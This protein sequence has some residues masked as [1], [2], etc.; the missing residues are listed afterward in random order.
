MGFGKEYGEAN[1]RFE[2]KGYIMISLLFNFA[3]GI[4]PIW[5]LIA[6]FVWIL[7]WT[8]ILTPLKLFVVFLH[9]LSH[10]AAAYL[11]GGKLLKFCVVARKG[12]HALTRGGSLFAILNAGYL[13]SFLWGAAIIL[14]T[15]WTRRDQELSLLIGL[16]TAV[17]TLFYLRNTFGFIFGIAFGTGLIVAGQ[18]FPEWANDILLRVIGFTCC[19]YAILDIFDDVILRSGLKS[20]ARM[21]AELT[22][23]PTVVWGV[24]W[25]TISSILMFLIINFADKS[26]L[27]QL[28]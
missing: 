22:G 3:A 28:A 5:M 9:E 19:S 13:G 1:N 23:I 4:S 25:I 14:A 11:T 2:L 15:S 18:I 16:A 17:I 26:N 7:W 21:L 6:L 8:P 27:Q 20:D 10:G 12:G 24:A